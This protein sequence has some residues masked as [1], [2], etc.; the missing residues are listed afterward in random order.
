MI[1][2]IQLHGTDKKL[3]E[4]VAP[5]VMNPAVIQYNQNYPFKTNEKYIWFIAFQNN[6]TVGFMPV[7]LR[8]NQWII[9]NYYVTPSIESTVFPA[10][11]QAIDQSNKSQLTAIV[12]VKHQ[13]YFVEQGFSIIKEWRKYLKMEKK[14]S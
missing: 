8:K 5:L 3:Y 6:E 11:L 12:Q 13:T 10:L 2:V 7:E 14:E 9:N 1:E 4:K